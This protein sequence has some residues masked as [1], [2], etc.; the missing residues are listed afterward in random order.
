MIHIAKKAVKTTFAVILIILGVISGFI[1]FVQGWILILA[2]LALLG[3]K[4]HHIR[5]K[6]HSLKECWWKKKQASIETE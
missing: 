2:G 5:E 4:P 1:P 6:W 3:I